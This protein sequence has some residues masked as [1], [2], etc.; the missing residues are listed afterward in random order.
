[1]EP[2]ESYL[3]GLRADHARFSRVLS[4]IGRDARRIVD[5]PEAVLPLFS[6]AVDYVVH[7]QNVHHHPREETMF[8]KV[9]GM[10]EPLA[11]TAAQLSQEH[12]RTDRVGD[13]AKHDREGFALLEDVH[14]ESAG[15]LDP[16]GAVAV[17]EVA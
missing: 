12:E 1:M 8:A 3:R 11:S 14:P 13:D 16:V 2:S 15:S 4:M 5:E 17:L 6:E 9:A 10:S 7:Y